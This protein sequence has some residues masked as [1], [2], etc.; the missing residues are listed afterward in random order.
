MLGFDDNHL[1]M[2]VVMMMPMSVLAMLVM[3]LVNLAGR[4][5]FHRSRACCRRE[6][7]DYEGQ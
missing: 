7:G 1:P 6:T 3:L 4:S 2:M 5:G